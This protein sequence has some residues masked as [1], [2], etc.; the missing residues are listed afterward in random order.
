[1]SGNWIISGAMKVNKILTDEEV[2]QINNSNGVEDLPRKQPLDL[3]KFWK[4]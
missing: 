3:N 4:N 2:E 1:M